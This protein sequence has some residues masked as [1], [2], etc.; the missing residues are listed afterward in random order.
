MM[1][2]ESQ[3]L[4]LVAEDTAS[5]VALPPQRRAI[6]PTLLHLFNSRSHVKPLPLARLLTIHKKT[7]IDQR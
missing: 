3:A 5:V 1:E 6:P 7:L 2:G 4:L